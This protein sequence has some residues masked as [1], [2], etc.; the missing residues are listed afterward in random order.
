MSDKLPIAELPHA[1][2]SSEFFSVLLYIPRSQ[3][4]GSRELPEL[5]NELFAN[6]ASFSPA[7]LSAERCGKTADNSAGI[8]E[9]ISEL[10][11]TLGI[12]ANLLGYE[13]LRYAVFA[14]VQDRECLRG[15][16]KRLYPDIAKHYST[17]AP[18]VERA[19]RHAIDVSCTR[20]DPKI[21]QD[22]FG[23]AI[24]PNSGKPT[25][26]AFI[27]KAADIVRRR[28]LAQTGAGR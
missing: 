9:K 27:S 2:S 12:P 24:N 16:T 25:N 19:I 15:I 3:L 8:F 11:D 10:L 14:A 20:G 1:V 23:N 21:L 7:E 13:Y 5:F 18:R 22:H 26:T 6:P 4:P 17:T 28:S